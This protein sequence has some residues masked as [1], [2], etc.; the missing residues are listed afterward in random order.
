MKRTVEMRA[1]ALTE[2]GVEAS[3]VVTVLWWRVARP[4]DRRPLRKN[5][6]QFRRG[7]NSF[8]MG[9]AVVTFEEGCGIVQERRR[10]KDVAASGMR[11]EKLFVQLMLKAVQP[12]T[13]SAAEV[14]AK[15][16]DEEDEENSVSQPQLSLSVVP[17]QIEGAME[18][19]D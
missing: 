12:D 9:K 8:D 2:R 3:V 13:H 11:P 10:E 18:G 6:Q 7:A 17:S 1:H 19:K 5:T 4:Q 14:N 15:E 16:E